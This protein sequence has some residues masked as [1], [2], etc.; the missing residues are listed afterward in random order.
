M[1]TKQDKIQ[2]AVNK[3]VELIYAMY[4]KDLKSGNIGRS[5]LRS[6]K[7]MLKGND[8]KNTL[9]TAICILS[10]LVIIIVTIF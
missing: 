8:D 9:F 5:V 6:P 2:I 3:M 1:M 7:K 4:L 10:C